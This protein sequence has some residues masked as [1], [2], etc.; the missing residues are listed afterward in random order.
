[1]SKYILKGG[2]YL[3]SYAHMFPRVP[4]INYAYMSP[5]MSNPP[6]KMTVPLNGP[7]LQQATMTPFGTLMDNP[8]EN[9]AIAT[10][11]PK[12]APFEYGNYKGAYLGSELRPI[13]MGSASNA[14]ERYMRKLS[15]SLSENKPDVSATPVTK[16]NM[17]DVDNKENPTTLTWYDNDGKAT[18]YSGSGILLFI[19]LPQ[20]PT[21]TPSSNPTSAS[22]TDIF[23]PYYWMRGGGPATMVI[24]FRRKG[25]EDNGKYMDLGGNLDSNILKSI[26]N[27]GYSSND[28][29][30]LKILENAIKEAREESN[31]VFNL[32]DLK[33]MDTLNNKIEV[34]HNNTYVSYMV[35]IDLS[36]KKP[37]EVKKEIDSIINTYKSFKKTGPG[38]D[39]TDDMIPFEINVLK[40][41]ISAGNTGILTYN[42][43][44]YT[45]APRLI[46][47]I[48]N[49]DISKIPAARQI[50]YK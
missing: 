9:S 36:S 3:A 49:L 15:E 14:K 37:D 45:L 13:G 1:M 7:I 16:K 32:S 26:V 33:N 46:N 6:A 17:W 27:N 29:V 22:W 39:E 5:Q 38:Y 47:I 20:P 12:F 42:I 40:N 43:K 10:M 50:K 23:K 34:S 21:P 25:G 35:N 8:L 30:K 11:S 24:L 44:S 28:E 18:T 4:N 2:S 31:D 19:T 41:Q 48:K